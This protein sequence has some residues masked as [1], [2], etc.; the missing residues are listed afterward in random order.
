[1][2]GLVRPVLS[3]EKMERGDINRFV[4]IMNGGDTKG[5]ELAIYKACKIL[6]PK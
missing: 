3:T 2:D 1:M 6:L 5:Q 4:V